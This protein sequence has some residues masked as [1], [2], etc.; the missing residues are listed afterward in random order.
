M[1]GWQD[2]AID[3]RDDYTR[4]AYLGITPL[5]G[6]STLTTITPDDCKIQ[7]LLREF[8]DQSKAGIVFVVPVCQPQLKP[9]RR[10]SGS[11]DFL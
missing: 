11:S 3:L 5:T 9:K 8:P 1:P 4:D 7:S 10:E 6:K 2:K